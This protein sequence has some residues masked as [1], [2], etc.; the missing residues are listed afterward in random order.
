MKGEGN[1]TSVTPDHNTALFPLQMESSEMIPKCDWKGQSPTFIVLYGEQTTLKLNR[2]EWSLESSRDSTTSIGPPKTLRPLQNYY[3][4]WNNTQDKKPAPSGEEKKKRVRQ[5]AQKNRAVHGCCV[6]VET[7]PISSLLRWTAE[8]GLKN[9]KE[10][11]K[12]YR[13]TS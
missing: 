12:I 2:A 11:V 8:V 10:M 7:Q 3:F 4:H 1:R 5:L 9:C 6:L 13:S